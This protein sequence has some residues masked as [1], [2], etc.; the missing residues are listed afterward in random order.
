MILWAR[1]MSTSC[2]Q[3]AKHRSRSEDMWKVC[4]FYSQNNKIVWFSN[5]ADTVWRNLRV[6]QRF[7]GFLF[8]DCASRMLI[9]GAGKLRSRGS[10]SL[11]TLGHV[12]FLYCTSSLRS[13]VQKACK[14][15][16]RNILFYEYTTLIKTKNSSLFTCRVYLCKF[17]PVTLCSHSNTHANGGHF[18]RQFT[19]PSFLIRKFHSH[20]LLYQAVH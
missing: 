6:A 17:C 10:N 9:G 12:Q 3:S 20:V 2:E 16:K 1:S 4:L 11:G 19:H 13:Y 8:L 14:Q 15:D 18:V 7:V 5:M